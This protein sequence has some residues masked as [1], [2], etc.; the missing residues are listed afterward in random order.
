MNMDTE[1]TY[2]VRKR[3]QDRGRIYNPGDTFTDLSHFYRPES[4]IRGG[5]LIPIEA[6]PVVETIPE[7]EPELVEET[8][9][10]S[11]KKRGRPKASK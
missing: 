1:I 8:P 5:W 10:T 3:F 4:M 11:P 6:E 7:K 9:V 2:L